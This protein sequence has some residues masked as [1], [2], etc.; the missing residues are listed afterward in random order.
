MSTKINSVI[1]QR[2]RNGLSGS[3]LKIIAVITMFIDHIGAVIFE[4]P[5]ITTHIM[6]QSTELYQIWSRTDLVLR[7]IGRIAFPIFCFLLVEGFLHTHN[8]KKYAERL[9]VFSLA[10]EI[11]FHLAIFGQFY[12][13]GHMNVF[14]TLLIGLIVLIGLEHFEKENLTSRIGR[15]V[16]IF[17]GIFIATFAN[18]DYAG[19]GIAIIIAFY[20]LHDNKKIRDIFSMAVLLCS[21]QLEIT[22]L[23][24]LIPIHLYNGKRG[25]SLKYFFYLFY[26]LHLLL[27]CGIRKLLLL[28]VFH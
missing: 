7:L 21:S 24:A 28:T 8:V 27:L 17:S 22:G 19:F 6:A 3:T 11:P 5:E 16:C 26:P 4:N 15:V 23:F 20:L 25:I 18:T 9:F 14:F 2:K 12:K 1:A 10:S 13:P